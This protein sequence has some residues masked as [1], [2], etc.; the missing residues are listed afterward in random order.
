MQAMHKR[1][2]IVCSF[3]H[4]YEVQAF[5]VAGSRAESST[6]CSTE[7]V[8]N[9]GASRGCPERNHACC[10][11]NSEPVLWRQL[12]RNQETESGQQTTAEQ[13]QCRCPKTG[14]EEAKASRE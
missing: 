8:Q 9:S 4:S 3:I 5:D 2:L 12:P 14:E 11:G 6:R 7:T 1:L 13:N 10:F